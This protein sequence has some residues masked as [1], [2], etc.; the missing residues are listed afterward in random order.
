MKLKTL[1]PAAQ[2]QPDQTQKPTAQTR[3]ATLEHLLTGD[4]GLYLNHV[5][6]LEP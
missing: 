1:S 5:D 3:Q 4:K 6:G 2:D